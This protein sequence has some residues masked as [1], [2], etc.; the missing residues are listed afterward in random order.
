[1]KTQNKNQGN[2]FGKY[3]NPVKTKTRS[4]ISAH[5]FITLFSLLGLLVASIVISNFIQKPKTVEEDVKPKTKKVQVYRIGEAPKISVQAQVEKSGV[6]TIAAL[7]PGVVSEVPVAPGNIVERGTVLV[8]TASNYGGGNAA[9]LQVSINAKNLQNANDSYET[10][11]E[12]YKKQK[13]LAKRTDEDKDELR[14]ITEK[15]LEETKTLISFN[16][17]LLATIDASIASALDNATR[18]QQQQAKSNLL[19]ANNSLRNSLRGNEYS[20]SSDEP[21]AEIANLTEEI[22]IKEIEIK[23]K[24]HE[25]NRDILRLNLA[26]SQVT[27]AAMTPSAPFAGTVQRVFVKVGQAIQPGTPLAVISQ[28][29]DEDPIVAVAYVPRDIANK[30]SYLEPSILT[31]GDYSYEAFPSYMTQDAVQGSLY[32]IYYPI[33]ENY[34]KFVT[35][36]GY[37]SVQ[38]PVGVFDTGAVV[39]YVPID[40]V[41]QTQS[42][43]Y[44]F[45]NKNG[46]AT[47]KKVV[48]GN[49]IGRYVEVNS[50]L[51][52][53]DAIILDRNVISG[54]PVT[55]NQ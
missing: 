44:I 35:D 13:E 20:S 17:E 18:Q 43:A 50:G 37:I 25:L 40:S 41:Y 30:A 39:P 49:V 27:A 9:A 28:T 45:I 1:M 12:I 33:P 15:S 29:V 42:D 11:K 3:F 23:E 54:D 55:T 7:A 31:I 14:E 47:S 38:V 26:V 36:A 4:F 53:G 22:A 8:S 19:N 24:A 32:A 10:Q 6:V 51:D 16:D 21:P 48:L 34:S 52:R 5:P 46:K 2:F